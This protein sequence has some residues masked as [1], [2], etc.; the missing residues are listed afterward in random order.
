MKNRIAAEA[1]STSQKPRHVPSFCPLPEGSSSEIIETIKEVTSEVDYCMIMDN[2]D[3]GTIGLRRYALAHQDEVDGYVHDVSRRSTKLQGDQQETVV[4]TIGFSGR[5]KR[6]TLCPSPSCIP[7]ADRREKVVGQWK[8]CSLRQVPDEDQ[9]EQYI[10]CVPKFM[11]EAYGPIA[12]KGGMETDCSV[13]SRKDF[14]FI[15]FHYT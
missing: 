8:I 14:C 12:D 6:W 13:F 11:F 7:K 2:Y 9:K 5:K 15:S 4:V 10:M 1:S 3:I